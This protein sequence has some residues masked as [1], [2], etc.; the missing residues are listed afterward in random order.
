MLDLDARFSI[1]NCEIKSFFVR[2][3]L[4]NNQSVVKEAI[5]PIWTQKMQVIYPILKF[6][7]VFAN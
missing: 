5:L 6:L 4:Q 3:N 2:A 1:R 7:T